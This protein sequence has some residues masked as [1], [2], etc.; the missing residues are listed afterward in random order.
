MVEVYGTQGLAVVF[1][2]WKFYILSHFKSK[3]LGFLGGGRFFSLIYMRTM[4]C[5]VTANNSSGSLCIGKLLGTRTDTKEN[6][7]MAQRLVNSLE[8]SYTLCMID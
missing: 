6:K 7:K 3:N 2:Y 4:N 8:S 1:M 5:K